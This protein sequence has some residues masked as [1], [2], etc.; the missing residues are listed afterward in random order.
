M[1]SHRCN[2]RYSIVEVE[3]EINVRTLEKLLEEAESA[4][5]RQKRKKQKKQKKS[6]MMDFE[7]W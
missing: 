3:G 4:I 1:F 7:D 6:S 5:N 2:F